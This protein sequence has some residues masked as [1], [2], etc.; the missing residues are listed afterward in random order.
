MSSILRHEPSRLAVLDSRWD[1]RVTKPSVA[2]DLIAAR[3]AAAETYDAHY[4]SKIAFDRAIFE[5]TN[6]TGSAR[7]RPMNRSA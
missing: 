7:N 4:R 5:A 3:Q 2:R 6:Y 1:Q